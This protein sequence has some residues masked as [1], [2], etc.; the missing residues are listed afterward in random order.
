MRKTIFITLSLI[1]ALNQVFPQSC[2]P[3]G[4]T[5]SLQSQIDD[6]QVNYPDCIEIEGDVTII[7]DNIQHLDGLN[8][9][10]AIGGTLTIDGCDDLTDITGLSNITYVGGDFFIE[11][12]TQLESLEGLSSLIEVGGMLHI[13]NNTALV[14]LNGFDNLQTIQG[15]LF[16]GSHQN[17]VSFQ[18]LENLEEIHGDLLVFNNDM[19][20]LDGLTSLTHI[21]G[22]LS[23]EYNN[24]QD[25]G[26]PSLVSVG[27]DLNVFYSPEL[28]SITGFDNL[29]TVGGNLNIWHNVNLTDISGFAGIDATSIANLYISENILL[30]ECAIQSVCDYLADPGG[31]V[32]I[33]INGPGCN[34]EEEVI[35]A[36]ESVTIP[37]VIQKE[38]IKLYPNP[39]N[40]LLQIEGIDVDLV[41]EV[42][43][44]DLCGYR[45]ITTNPTNGSIDISFLKPG[46]YTLELIS[47]VFTAKVRFVTQ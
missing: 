15:I 9:L 40:A 26:I 35:E 29:E 2:L 1:L 38:Q 11:N 24:I 37:V 16:V 27:D 13:Q 14:S 7:Y 4:I 23:I 10:E 45:V 12:T 19:V 32:Q 30:R 39:A 44:Y 33:L 43:V 5:F 6:F 17:L 47:E 46:V 8:V 18:G 22:R 41:D 3:Q 31:S 20:S 21:S 34:N 36:C 25:I 42:N 28:E